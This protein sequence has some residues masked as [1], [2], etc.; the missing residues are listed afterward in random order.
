[1]NS[2]HTSNKR[3]ARRQKRTQEILASALQ[4]V[5]EDGVDGLTVHKLAKRMDCAVGAMYRYFS[6]KDALLQA[7]QD[8]ALTAFAAHLEREITGEGLERVMAAFLAWH[9]FAE[10]EPA[11]H[12]L[13]DGALSDPHRLLSDEAATAVDARLR[14]V[15][16]IGQQTLLDAQEAGL[17]NEGD[18]LIRSYAMFA[19]VHGT[20]HF[21]KRD[22]YA[23]VA[24]SDVRRELMLSLLRGW[25]ATP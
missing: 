10:A 3:S 14:G 2:V 7:L 1:V 13:L 25:G 17:L 4:I 19:A 20:E 9:G 6:G 11:L 12:A 18:A 24:S 16:A 21:R 22:G 15:M 8:H 23:E 5:V